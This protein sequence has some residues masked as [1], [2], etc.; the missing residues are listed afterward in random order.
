MG[1]EEKGGDEGGDCMRWGKRRRRRGRER[2]RRGLEDG[3]EREDEK[4]KK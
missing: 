2:W 3:E 4:G 1:E